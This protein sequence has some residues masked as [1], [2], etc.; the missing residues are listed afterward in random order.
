MPFVQEKKVCL[1]C[2]QQQTVFKSSCLMI[3]RRKNRRRRRSSFLNKKKLCK[4]SGS[5]LR[6]VFS[7]NGTLN[8]GG[9]DPP[10]SSFCCRIFKND[11]FAKSF[12]V[13]IELIGALLFFEKF[14]K[15]VVFFQKYSCIFFETLKK[16]TKIDIC[17]FCW[18]ADKV[19]PHIIFFW[20][21]EQIPEILSLL[22]LKSD[23]N[24]RK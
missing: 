4:R 19:W 17:F 21:V 3:V 2:Q 18:E 14:Q 6:G 9:F 12:E 24:S 1:F 15:S 23:K 11:F 16:Q 7:K 22:A 20:K 10:P 13:A 8:C 5:V